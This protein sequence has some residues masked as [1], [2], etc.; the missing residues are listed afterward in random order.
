[1]SML[2]TLGCSSDLLIETESFTDKGGWM[3][4]QQ[5]MDIMGSPYLIAH[6]AGVP[7]KDASTTVRLPKKGEWHAYVRT[8]N[9]TS[10][11]HE[12]EG[13]GK[14]RLAIDG[15]ETAEI[16]GC[17]G[18]RWMWEYA[19][20][21]ITDN[22]D[23][24]VTL[25]DLTGFDGRCD[26]ILFT[27][28]RD[29]VLPDSAE[30]MKM[31]RER[32]LDGYGK[33]QNQ[34]EYDLVV[35]GGGVAGICAAVS[36]A[37]LGLKVALVH[38]RP[39][40]GGNNS[41]EVRVHLGGAIECGPYPN[42]GNLIKEFGHTTFGNA[43]DADSYEDWKKMDIV[44]N[45]KNISLFLNCHVTDVE[46]K[47]DKITSLLG[48]DI[49]SGKLLRFKAPLFAD[50]TGDASVG[51]LAGADWRM[52]RES[53]DETGE[54]GAVAKADRQVLGTS[55]QWNSKDTGKPSSF[56]VFEYGKVFTEESVQK[57]T[58]GEWTWETGM[59]RD[60]IAEAER[61]RDH[62]LLVI[63]SNWSYL[64]NRSSA[65]EEY[66]SL[67]LDWVAHIAGKRES[68]RLMGDHV[69]TQTDIL[70]KVMYPDGSAAATWS[71]DL[72]YPD[73]DNSKFFPGEEFKAVCTQ[74]P[75]EIYPIPYR[76]FYSRN[77]SNL[78]MAGRNISVTHVALGT[79]RVMRTTAM[80]GEVVGMAAAVCSRN[81]CSPRGV[82]ETYLEELK[83]LMKEGCGKKG[84]EN[85][86]LFNIGRSRTAPKG[87]PLIKVG[88]VTD[89]H[90]SDK[91]PAIGRQY[92]EAV[93][94]FSQAVETFN[95]NKVSFV[96]SLGD[97]VDNDFGIYCRLDSVFSKLHSPVRH[98][99]GNHDYVKPYDR[100]S[101]DSLFR[102]MGMEKP[103][104]S[105]SLSGRRFLFL[106]AT[107]IAV[108]SHPE[109]SP[110]AQQA[111]RIM[112]DIKDRGGKN[113]KSYNGGI[114]K[115]QKEWI[116]AQLKAATEKD[117]DVICFC[118]MPFR[119]ADSQYILYNSEEMTELF[120]SWE[121][122][123]AVISGHHHAG[124]Y[125]MHDGIH[126]LTL[127][128]MVQGEDN[129]YA[130][131]EIYEDRMEIKGFGREE[132]NNILRF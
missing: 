112:K 76:C 38:N 108:Y 45:E 56:P 40:L 63:Y 61:I 23:I 50:C 92:R 101:Q 80:M 8:F 30:E 75:I 9:W 7:V 123:K 107:D 69:L 114:G 25:K 128:G 71:I 17:T 12:G 83:G 104:Y 86:Q 97:L 15:Q 57:V 118:H 59:L 74:T 99:R 49:E 125:E 4:D 129:S 72:H 94:R 3:T 21:F 1:M 87:K 90:H 119:P 130:I 37:R 29:A 91:E 18:D 32:L 19:G 47:G 54:P 11:W 78:F 24:D 121:C 120:S 95:R 115:E 102:I 79:V 73:P 126:Y 89:I 106:D 77:I 81:D 96:V 39:V 131:A 98:T 42:L 58:K 2:L 105:M 43:N 85:N 132:S 68:R 26:A 127:K 93:S 34:G 31:M 5:F 122:V 53:F 116:E 55:V 62:G 22:K 124:G 51:Y 117:E 13:P 60:Q 46:M 64:K 111:Q 67:A 14:F 66:A 109:D 41:S 44:R 48:R 10:P 88:L 113:A 82:Y 6:G 70:D 33:A 27:R 52:G 35:A 103:Y 84:L 65:K 100:E 110:E 28:E 36:A 16:L 20:S